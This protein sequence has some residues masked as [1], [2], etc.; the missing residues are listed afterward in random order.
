MDRSIVICGMPHENS[1]QLRGCDQRM[2]FAV[3][4]GSVDRLRQS[5]GRI[6]EEFHQLLGKMKLLI[7]CS[8][9]L[10]NLWFIY[11]PNYL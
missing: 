11:C 2:F 5:V 4:F 10:C 8:C 6:P 1:S 7:N 3:I 9:R